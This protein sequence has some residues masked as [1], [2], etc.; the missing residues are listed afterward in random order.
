MFNVIT[1]ERYK[2]CTHEFKDLVAGK[3]GTTP[4]AIDDDF[5]KKIIGDEKPVTCRPA[6]LLS[7]ELETLKQECAQWTQQEEDVLSYAMFRNVAVDFFKKRRDAQA[8]IDRANLDE[9]RQIHPV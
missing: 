6:D 2:M 5:R 7:P 8:G 3:Y 4:V 1:G 9:K